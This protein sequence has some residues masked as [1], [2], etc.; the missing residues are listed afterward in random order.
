[1]EYNS[2]NTDKLI[3]E[4]LDSFTYTPREEVWKKLSYKLNSPSTTIWDKLTIKNLPDINLKS[5]FYGISVASACFLILAVFH[6][7]LSDKHNSDTNYSSPSSI[8]DSNFSDSL[9][10]E[11]PVIF[12]PKT[13]SQKEGE[14]I[15]RQEEE[16]LN[17]HESNNNSKKLIKEK[18]SSSTLIEPLKESIKTNEIIVSDSTSENVFPKESLIEVETKSPTIN[19]KN[20]LNPTQFYNVSEDST[21]HRHLFNKKK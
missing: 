15:I 9:K 18:E 16:S 6:F 20:K 7:V 11:A 14:L 2:K 3:K 5:F 19:K 13:Y 21:G 1:M 4:K 12:K 17:I 10:E 8:T